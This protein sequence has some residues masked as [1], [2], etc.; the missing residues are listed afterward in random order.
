MADIVVMME[1]DALTVAWVNRAASEAT[2]SPC[3]LKHRLD[4]VAKQRFKT[5]ES[6]EPR[7]TVGLDP[8]RR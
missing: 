3:D 6:M 4:A 2:G 1:G 7:S 8:I 5:G